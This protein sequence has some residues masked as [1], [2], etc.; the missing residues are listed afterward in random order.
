MDMFG[1]FGAIRRLVA[2]VHSLADTADQIN[3][4]VRQQVGL[5][6]LPAL[7]AIEHRADMPHEAS[8]PHE[9]AVSLDGGLP[10]LPRPEV[11]AAVA[12]NGKR[13]A[14]SR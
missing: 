3:Q 8:V 11:A 2:S 7:P 5:P 9:P 14:T 1:I 13:K 12:S 4:G 10:A 6:T